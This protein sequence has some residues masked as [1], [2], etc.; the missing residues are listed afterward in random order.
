MNER[1]SSRALNWYGIDKGILKNNQIM[2]LC[3]TSPKTGIRL[4]KPGG[5]FYGV[6]RAT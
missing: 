6:K 1:V 4:P 2:I 3:Y 5:S